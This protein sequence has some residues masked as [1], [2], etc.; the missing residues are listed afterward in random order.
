VSNDGIPDRTFVRDAHSIYIT[1]GGTFIPSFQVGAAGVPAAVRLRPENSQPRAYHFNPDGTMHEYSYGSRDFRPN[2]STTVGGTGSSLRNYGFVT[3]EIE[4]MGLN[5]ISHFDISDGLSLFAEGKFVQVDTF[6][7]TS[8]SFNQTTSAAAPAATGSAGLVVRLTNPYLAPATVTQLQGLLP[9]G[10][11]QFTLNRNNM[12]IGV[13]GEDTQRETSRIVLGVKGAP[14]DNLN[15]EFSLNYGQLKVNTDVLGNRYERNLRLAVDAARDASGNIVCRSRLG[16]GN[17]VVV[18]NDAAIDTCVPVNV[19]GEGAASAEAAAYINAASTFEAN[20]KQQVASG[21]V[22]YQMPYLELPGGK[23]GFAFGAEYRKEESDAT[24]S[25]DVI[26]GATFLNAIQPLDKE[27]AVKE[28]FAEARFPILADVPFAKE[29]T[30]NGSIRAA[31][32]NL[33][34]TNSTIIAWNGGLQWAPHDDV[35]LRVNLSSAVRAPT[36]ADL[37]QP[38]TQNYATVRDPCDIQNVSQGSTNRVANCAAAGIPADF[39]NTVSRAQTIEI[40]S[41]GNTLLTE[42]ESRSWTFGLVYEPSQVD[43]L[44]LTFDYY[45]IEVS[46]VIASVTAQQILDNCYDGASLVNLYCPLVHRDGVTHLFSTTANPDA[47]GF[48]GGVKQVPLNYSARRARGIDAEFRFAGGVGQNGK[49]DARLLGTYVIQRDN[50]PFPENPSRPDQILWELGDPEL[51]WNF[52]LSYAQGPVTVAYGFRWLGSQYVDFIENVRSVGGRAPENAD[53]SDISFTG[54]I[55]YHDVRASYELRDDTN[56][57]LG[58]DN[59]TDKMPP[60]GFTGTGAGSSIYSPR[61]RYWYAGVK[62]DL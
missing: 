48:G 30:L 59:L 53:F 1:E 37:Y 26:N 34:N 16:A 38:L 24:Y 61:G 52:D 56:V 60:L 3:P 10:A 46:K 11:T 5:L 12:D 33:E 49:I 39:I 50:Y 43:G 47:D 58:V 35:R 8:P 31:D 4:R 6:S 45:D 29:L 17:V 19:L 18:T 14:T 36:I 25:D 15:Y 62:W 42:E 20:V 27:Y 9:T 21:F 23:M 51:A 55:S 57:Y 54:H 44:S 28:L 41:G 7:L 22:S 13:R 2:A 40:R 32:Y